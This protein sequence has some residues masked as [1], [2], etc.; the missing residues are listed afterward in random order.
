MFELYSVFVIDYKDYS[1]NYKTGSFV[2]KL[3][4]EILKS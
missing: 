3:T 4:I 2:E 1:T